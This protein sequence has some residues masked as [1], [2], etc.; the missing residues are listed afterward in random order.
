MT[1]NLPLALDC[2][3]VTVILMR[4]RRESNMGGTARAM[5]TM[6]YTRLVFV[7]PELE[8]GREARAV[9]HGA[10]DVLDGAIVVE[11]LGE[12][13]M[14]HGVTVGFSARVG[15]DRAR[16]VKLRK[17]VTEILPLYLPARVALVFGSEESGLSLEDLEHCQFVVQIPTG[18]AHHSLNLSHAVMVACYE[19]HV[20]CSSQPA[21]TPAPVLVS[22]DAE[23]PLA[24]T[25][26]DILTAGEP[27]AAREQRM[28][29]LYRGV[30]A[31]LE[32]IAYPNTSSRARAMADVRRVLGGAYLTQRDVNTILGTFRHI[33]YLLHHG[34]NALPPK[35][36]TAPSAEPSVEEQ[37]RPVPSTGGC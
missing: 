4:T 12:A 18:P 22:P 7:D 27:P 13:V 35:E 10:T 28:V 5:K 3:D 24:A 23:V 26:G 33:R 31:F 17:F 11:T 25:A 32:D 37:D 9:A 15:K 34:R 6:G 14:G 19:M 30:E 21:G 1:S 8:P 2:D 36:A 16:P 20:A 29:S